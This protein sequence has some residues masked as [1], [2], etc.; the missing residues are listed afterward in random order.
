MSDFYNYFKEN[1]EA[2]NLLRTARESL[3]NAAA[4]DWDN[5]HFPRLH[6]KVRNKSDRDGDD[7][8]GHQVGAAGRDERMRRRLL[9]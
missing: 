8:R 5:K 9:H 1:M 7:R 6:R 3:W 4:C 2:L